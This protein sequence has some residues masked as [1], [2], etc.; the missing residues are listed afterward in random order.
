MKK[1][2][3][4]LAASLV[5]AFGAQAADVKLVVNADQPG[6]VI[7]RNIYGQFAEHLGTGIYEGMW[8]G[9][10]SKI[11][12]VRGWRKDVVAALK[13]LK[14]PL[15]RWPGGCFADEYH[16]RDGIGP[17]A[18][19]P[20]K[21]NTHWGGVPENNAVGTHE[22]FDLVEQLGAEAYVNGN[23][24]T[25]SAQEMAEWLEYMTGEGKSTLT[26]MRRKNGRDK[27]FRVHYF[28]VG[29]E[30]WGCGG[31]MRPEYYADQ[32]RQVATFLKTPENNRPKFIASGGNDQDT[33]W[34]EVLS[35]NIRHNF[36][37]IAHHAYTF[38]SGKWEG[39]GPAVGFPEAEWISMLSQVSKI[40]STLAKSTVILDKNDPK[41]KL[42]IYFDEWGSWYDPEPGSNPGFLVQRNTLRDALLAALHF[43]VFHS[44]AD[45]VKM[46]N[47]AQ[48]V[49]VL[50]AMIQTSKDKL[51]LTP[52]YHAFALYTPFQDAT[53]LPTTLENNPVYKV[54][55][56]EM[57]SLSATAARGKDGKLYVGL[58]NSNA[59]Q[60]AELTLQVGAN[61]PKAAKGRLLTADAMDAQNELGKPAQVVP[62]AYEAQAAD[63]KLTLKL[64]AKSIVVVAIE[65]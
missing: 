17:R 31:N 3:A 30:T 21:I 52:T 10:Q 43:N 62:R 1:Q 61:A 42:A 32:Y 9:P 23:L 48:M 44:H 6:P 16:W 50:Q 37:A 25:G 24:G 57:P 51:V 11:P 59:T 7:H 39:K 38:P 34:T 60:A 55:A 54:G 53:S 20:V 35:K 15:V 58:V 47:I 27:P 56:T 45:R 26:D 28:A 8:V 22:F 64:P 40:D 13:E 4:A 5:W 33:T 2:L 18:K 36:D 46:S 41:K 29:N 19:R 12:N 49:N 63:G 65:G 14:V